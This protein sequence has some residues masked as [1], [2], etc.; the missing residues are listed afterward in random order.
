MNGA[1]R[2]NVELVFSTRDYSKPTNAEVRM[3]SM[4]LSPPSRTKGGTTDLREPSLARHVAKRCPA[5]A[6]ASAAA[7]QFFSTPKVGGNRVGQTGLLD[8]TLGML[9]GARRMVASECHTVWDPTAGEARRAGV[10]T[11]DVNS[12]MA[13]KLA[14]GRKHVRVERKRDGRRHRVGHLADRLVAADNTPPV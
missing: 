8:P 7:A 2:V 11:G 3:P 12:K 4:S 9:L 13:S 1:P 14:A 6:S 10:Y 5:G